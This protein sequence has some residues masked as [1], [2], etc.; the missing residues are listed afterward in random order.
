MKEDCRFT[1]WVPAKLPVHLMTV[2]DIQKA[3][4]I[5]L[6]RRVQFSSLAA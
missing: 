4:I 3:R 2:T 1:F 5:W 6:D